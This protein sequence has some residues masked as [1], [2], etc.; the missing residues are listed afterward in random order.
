MA[1]CLGLCEYVDDLCLGCGR[2]FSLMDE[3][4]TT[5]AAPQ[6]Q[7]AASQNSSGQT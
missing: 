5:E 6:G 7:D 2:D 4:E 3:P 1:D